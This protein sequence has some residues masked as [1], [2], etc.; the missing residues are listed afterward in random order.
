M[1]VLGC[2]EPGEELIGQWYGERSCLVSYGG[3]SAW[4]EEPIYS[5][6]RVGRVA[7]QLVA[8]LDMRTEGYGWC[9]S[10]IEL[11]GDSSGRLLA[12]PCDE[13]ATITGGALAFDGVTLRVSWRGRHTLA[14]V[15]GERSCEMTAR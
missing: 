15:V 1:L 9:V 12:G 6:A 11:V 3:G 14:G 10:R 13:S 2:A 7:G 4:A 8:E 5:V